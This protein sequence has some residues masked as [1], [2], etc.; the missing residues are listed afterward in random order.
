[1]KA[2]VYT[3]PRRMELR[4]LPLPVIK[5]REVLIKIKAAGICGS[6]KNGFLGRSTKRV[7]PLVLGHEFSGEIVDAGSEVSRFRVGQAVAVYPLI[8]CGRC[9][10]CTIGQAHLCAERKLFGLD[11]NGALAEYVAVPDQCVF[12]IPSNVGFVAAA[13]A[14][15]LAVAL[16]V[17]EH[18]PNLSSATGLIYGAGSLGVLVCIAAKILGVRS[19]AVVEK[20]QHRL[21]V[22]KQLGADLIVNSDRG[23]SI[24]KILE[25]TGRRGVDFSV[26]AVGHTICRKEAV[27]LTRSG[28]IILLVGLMDA[29]TE[30]DTATIIARELA[31][32]GSYAYTRDNFEKS[33]CLIAEGKIP[34][35]LF[36]TCVQLGDGPR[37]FEESVGDKSRWTKVVFC[38]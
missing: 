18:I 1:M 19:I 26:D 10:Y 8:T 29:L 6:D 14:E 30:F 15:P 21:E 31:V 34:M 27:V 32:K 23:D 4:D 2:L 13:L 17:M 3:A 35:E 20:N 33:L 22:V 37:V 38:T 12:A 25:W 7:P 11:F 16:H 5:S 9:A 28:G 36:V 24:E